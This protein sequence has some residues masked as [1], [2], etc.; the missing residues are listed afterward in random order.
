MRLPPA[1]LVALW[2][3]ADPSGSDDGLRFVDISAG[4]RHTCALTSRGV[5]FCWGF[6]QFGQLGDSSHT[7][8][9]RPVAVTGGLRFAS[10]SAGYQHTCAISNDGRLYC[11][12]SNFNGEIGDG[13]QTNRAIPTQ[14]RG[15]VTFLQVS[16]GESHTCAVATG[17]VG[18]CWG[19]P[20]GA[21]PGIDGRPPNQL[22]PVMLDLQPLTA[23]S[24]GY[25][26]ACAATAAS[27]TAYCWGRIPPGIELGPNEPSPGVPRLVA[28]APPLRAISAGHKHACGIG[29][30]GITYC[31]GRNTSGETGTGAIS[32]TIASPEAVAGDYEFA[33]VSAHAPTH[34]CALDL[35]GRAYCWGSNAF[36]ELGNGS[37]TSS[38]VPTAVASDLTFGTISTGFSFSCAVTLDGFAWCWGAGA[39]GQL[40]SGAYS[41][42]D[43]PVPVGGS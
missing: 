21:I 22:Q 4:S 23:V 34:T 40:G 18:Y 35:E 33:L 15:G 19:A 16:T 37:H 13:T 42:A 28:D 17:G 8:S 20:L 12:G 11:W 38:G 25:E 43:T 31:W 36:G 9:A 3:C 2:A 29:H 26:I 1:L 32:D 10:I 41:D 14:V 6:N 39:S 27:G 24:A 30:D 7:T 5:A